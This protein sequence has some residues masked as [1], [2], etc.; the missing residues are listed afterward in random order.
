MSGK[1]VFSIG[2]LVVL[3]SPPVMAAET[4][5]VSIKT[6]PGGHKEDGVWSALEAARDGK[7]YMGLCSHGGSGQFYVYNPA[8]GAI[9][10]IATIQ[11]I[12]NELPGREPQGKLHSQMLED[13]QGR[14]WFG[15]D[16]S[17]P[18][19]MAKWDGPRAYPG[20]HMMVYD[21]ANK[22]LSDLGIL[23][24]KAALR[25]MEMD[26]ER[27]KIYGIAYPTGQFYTY[28]MKTGRAAAKGRVSNWD[29]VSRAI[30]LDDD[31]NVYGSY[32]PYRIFKYDRVA[33]KL[34]DLPVT[35][36]HQDGSR[37]IKPSDA[38]ETIWRKPV[39]HPGERVIYAMDRGSS[40]LFRFNP[41]SNVIEDL[42]RLAVDGYD[43]N[44]A[45]LL[46][47]LTLVLDDQGI[48]YYVALDGSPQRPCHL[49]AYDTKTGH[50][51]DLGAMIDNNAGLNAIDLQA[52]DIG[53]DGAI[54]FTGWVRAGSAKTDNSR[55]LG[56][57]VMGMVRV[58]RTA[59]N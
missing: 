11:D 37:S 46:T 57:T 3:C 29:T 23:F 14:I 56:G 20:G 17:Y 31:G 53:T 4:L 52:A 2:L 10:H 9:D 19:F 47:T 33:D 18:Y 25:V 22:L 41:R 34:V 43:G 40:T 7:I 24:P 16:M 5:P 6:F 48:L 8:D 49:I 58:D 45:A 26:R 55:R 32:E 50:K 12:V 35:I 27:E 42:G 36:P 38:R 1:R 59:L 15:T 51:R 28:D 13:N 30:V 54:Y 44:R 39:W 21:P